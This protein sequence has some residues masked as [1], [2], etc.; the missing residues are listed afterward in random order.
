LIP[1]PRDLRFEVTSPEGD[2]T[3]YIEGLHT[4]DYVVLNDWFVQHLSDWGWVVL[5]RRRLGP[6]VR[7][8]LAHGRQRWIV[9]VGRE[10]D[11]DDNPRTW[12]NIRRHPN[13]QDIASLPNR[14]GSRDCTA[15]IAAT[16]ERA[17]L[18]C[19]LQIDPGIGMLPDSLTDPDI[20]VAGEETALAFV[21]GRELMITTVSA[22]EIERSPTVVGELSLDDSQTASPQIMV[23]VDGGWLLSWLDGNPAERRV[24]HFDRRLRQTERFRLSVGLG[25]DGPIGWAPIIVR[26]HHEYA[27]AWTE[28]LEGGVLA[29]RA[30]GVKRDGTRM[31]RSG[32]FPASGA[33]PTIGPVLITNGDERLGISWGSDDG[34]FFRAVGTDGLPEAPERRLEPGTPA[35]IHLAYEADSFW[36]VW[37]T[38]S[39]GGFWRRTD[40]DGCVDNAYG[41]VGGRP[42]QAWTSEYGPIVQIRQRDGVRL[43]RLSDRDLQEPD[44]Q[45]E[46]VGSDPVLLD[47]SDMEAVD[48]GFA[49]MVL[50]QDGYATARWSCL[51]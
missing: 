2:R 9:V 30:A 17:A 46:V 48:G 11:E 1:Y 7:L 47:W 13:E 24:A 23:G 3:V 29:F 38:S 41:S 43:V 19:R 26:G 33:E 27:A 21:L 20:A 50:T 44:R 32:R 5:D 49:G 25:L 40:L 42:M 45:P 22:G 18:S 12:L 14:S 36:I 10:V 28:H 4:I 37:G 51:Q 31:R 6:S 35:S 39:G 34:L 8:R 16:P 15:G